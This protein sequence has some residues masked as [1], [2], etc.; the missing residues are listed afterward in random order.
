MF[1]TTGVVNNEIVKELKKY[2]V[3]SKL[4]IFI[5]IMIVICVLAGLSSIIFAILGLIGT[6]QGITFAIVFFVGICVFI[7]EYYYTLYK[8]HK[9]CMQR[10]EE[11]TGRRET[12]YNVYFDEEGAIV[13]NL[14]TKSNIKMKYDMFVRLGET[15]NVY[16]LFTKSNLFIV[17][18]KDCLDEMQM[19][20]FKEFI[21]EKCKNIK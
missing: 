7:A 1:E 20:D 6:F 11:T 8:F 14:D 15:S 21:K 12:K 3:S 17:I 5:G 19:H 18:F 10:M 13:N 16:A 4:K 2:L 9:I